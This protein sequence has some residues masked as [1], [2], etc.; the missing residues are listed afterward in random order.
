MTDTEAQDLNRWLQ[1]HLFSYEDGHLDSQTM[2]HHD[3]SVFGDV[4]QL[5]SWK[6]M[7]LVKYALRKRGFSVE[8]TIDT[9]GYIE[10]EVC[11]DGYTGY[12]L[13]LRTGRGRV[14]DGNEPLAVAHAARAA[15]EGEAQ[16][17]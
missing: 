4:A 7:G 3:V 6:G 8:T 12:T 11:P 10:A 13:E 14:H 1:A 16:G 17:A 15:L 5:V 2:Y 9:S